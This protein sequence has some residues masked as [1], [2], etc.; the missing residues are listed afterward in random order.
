MMR[1]GAKHKP[2]VITPRVWPGRERQVCGDVL[3]R[4]DNGPGLWP[5]AGIPGYPAS[6]VA[7]IQQS[8]QMGPP[9]TQS[10]SSS[11]KQP[12]ISAGHSHRDRAAWCLWARAWSQIPNPKVADL[13][14]GTNP[15]ISLGV[16]FLICKTELWIMP[17]LRADTSPYRTCVS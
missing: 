2:P 9:R 16:S 12:R 3:H 17:I 1:A 13:W 14:A 8:P 4:V 5:T 6:A 11:R 7:G 15:F 10:D